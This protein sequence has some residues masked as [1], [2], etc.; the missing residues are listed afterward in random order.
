M[1][2][3]LTSTEAGCKRSEVICKE[4]MPY[5]GIRKPEVQMPPDPTRRLGYGFLRTKVVLQLVSAT[6]ACHGL[7]LPQ[8]GLRTGRMVGFFEA[9][10]IA[11][12]NFVDARDCRCTNHSHPKPLLFLVLE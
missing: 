2:S 4:S 3:P 5:I 12:R 1:R 11:S 8:P 9:V 7:V 10:T 6:M